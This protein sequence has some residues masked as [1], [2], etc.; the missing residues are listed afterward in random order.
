[1]NIS[2]IIRPFECS[3][4][5]MTFHVR[6]EVNLATNAASTE[7]LN[8]V[9]LLR[10]RIP[11]DTQDCFSLTRHATPS[12]PFFIKKKPSESMI[13]EGTETDPRIEDP[14]GILALLQRTVR[15]D[16]AIVVSE[17]GNLASPYVTLLWIIT[18]DRARCA[19]RNNS[20]KQKETRS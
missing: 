10:G 16:D 1:M 11:R 4:I 13:D 15:H 3:L 20:P 12:R 18:S 5:G 17:T 8:K 9:E 7:F 2:A 6:D 14:R 19:D